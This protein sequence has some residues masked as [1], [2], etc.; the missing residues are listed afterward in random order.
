MKKTVTLIIVLALT[1]MTTLHLFASGVTERGPYFKEL[2]LNTATLEEMEKAWKY[3][4]DTYT[5]LR[6]T[7]RS[8][9]D[10]AM[11]KRDI[12]GYMEMR[13]LYSSLEYP[14]IT[15]EQTE[16]LKERILNTENQEDKD[17]LASFVYE[18]S[19]FYRPTLVFDYSVYNGYYTTPYKKAVSARPG[20]V[21]TVPEVKDDG[22]F[23]GWSLDGETV[24]YKSGE[25]ITMP[26]SDTVL[27]GIFS[28]GISFNDA[29]T[30]NNSY[31]EGTE[32]RV[33]TPI[34]ENENLIFL[35]WYDIS[36]K[37]L[38]GDRITVKRGESK[39]YTA[40]WEGVEISN[41]SIRYYE[42]GKIPANTQVILSIHLKNVGNVVLR[43]LKVTIAG[44]GV[45]VL[46]SDL[47]A[48]LI[49][50]GT[51][52]NASFIVYAE[53]EKGT[54]KTITA[55]VSDASGNTWTKDFTFII[56]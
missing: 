4:V 8:A 19:A 52:A 7:L 37:K 45:K 20:T 12:E 51:T 46:S 48:S 38:E 18:N 44:N 40:L 53:G 5:S 2:D 6:S 11:D 49:G 43:N 1:F 39:E 30:G 33:P 29:I 17:A 47:E 32:A 10:D 42:E 41:A 35:G 22:V 34:S 16:T 14:I 9:M 55:T 56:Q 31:V 21:V 13:S 27:Y 36:G 50:I 3:S 25:E 23:L 28:S 15:K 26:Y 54:E 24:F